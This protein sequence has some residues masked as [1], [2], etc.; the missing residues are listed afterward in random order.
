M[1]DSGV[2]D[3]FPKE[4]TRSFAVKQARKE[5]NQLLSRL[6]LRLGTHGITN[7]ATESVDQFG[8]TKNTGAQKRNK[9][10]QKRDGLN[11]FRLK[12]INS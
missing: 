7:S 4:L 9:L 12:G 2:P 10:A 6:G 11:N 1:V 8:D 5:Q 3:E